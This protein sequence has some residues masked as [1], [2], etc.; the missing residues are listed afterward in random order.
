MTFEG[1]SEIERIGLGL[2]DRTLPKSHWTHAGHFAAAIWLLRH[3]PMLTTPLEIGRIIRAYNE[4]TN[5]PNTD[6]GGYHDTITRASI[7][8]ASAHLS[9]YPADAELHIIVNDLMASPLGHPD[10]LLGYW[11]RDRLFGTPARRGWV[12]PDLASIP[13]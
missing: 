12:E 11:S 7:R 5:T 9:S 2:L 13:F 8:A 10:W 3:R 1:D 6:T 4:A